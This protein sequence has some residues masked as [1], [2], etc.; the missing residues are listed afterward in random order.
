M[1][2]QRVIDIMQSLGSA[3][4]VACCVL[5]LDFIQKKTKKIYYY[6]DFV[7]AVAELNLNDPIQ[8]VQ[9][10]LNLFKSKKLAILRQ[11]YRYLDDDG[12]VYAVEV[13]DLQGAH[14]DGRLFLEWRNYSDPDFASKV[15]IVFFAG[16]GAL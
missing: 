11:E 9:R 6:A 14:L 15:Y 4:D 16:D 8:L 10:S 13:E 5:L 7:G 2:K 12:V 1:D 3:E